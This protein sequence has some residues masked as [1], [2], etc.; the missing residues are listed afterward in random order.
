MSLSSGTMSVGIM[1]IFSGLLGAYGLRALLLADQEQAITDPAP[2]P[3][4]IT[5]P[6]AAADLPAGRILR[7]GD[8][9]IHEM[10]AEQM[11]AK[12]FAD[13]SVMLSPQQI[14][15][16]MIR[17]PVV[18]GQPFKTTVMYLQDEQPDMSTMLQP[19]E[20]AISIELPELRGGNLQV[21]TM[22]DV[23]FRADQTTVGEVSI[24]EGTVTLFEGVRI[25]HVREGQTVVD[26]ARGSRQISIGRTATKQTSPVVTLAV[27][28]EQANRLRTA[29]GNGAISLVPRSNAD[30]IVPGPANPNV[31]TLQDLLGISKPVTP[32]QTEIFRGNGKSIN[33]FEETQL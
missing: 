32:P 2:P 24:P 12:G 10:T 9:G 26:A 20:R 21:G 31:M 30:P 23:L 25:L 11:R 27:S 13:A 8:I 33:I 6:L 18:Q 1:A 19:G 7:L 29:E 14:M 3:A 4:M 16:R 22:V 5:I 28:L 15:G 17:E